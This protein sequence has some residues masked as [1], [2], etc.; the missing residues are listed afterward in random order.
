MPFLS[1]LAVRR[2][3]ANVWELTEPFCYRG[4]R[5]TFTVPAGFRTDFASV[6]QWVQ[7]FIPRTG[8]SDEAA[9]LH[10]WLCVDLARN[11]NE[12]EADE[13]VTPYASSRDTD[14]LFRRLLRE[15]GC[16]FVLRWLMWCGVRWGAAANPARRA[17]WWRDS[18]AVAAISAVVLA[19]VAAV[20]AGVHLAVDALWGW[21]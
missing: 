13:R 19:V 18:P 8:P 3:A 1:K 2:E 10:D 5:E 16:G 4:R 9:V 6:P 7:S 15:G 11:W 12:R 21:L 17:G 14:G 20:A